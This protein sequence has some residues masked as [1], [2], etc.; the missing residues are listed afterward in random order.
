MGLIKKIEK[1]QTEL[2]TFEGY[3]TIDENVVC[4]CELITSEFQNIYCPFIKFEGGI[5]EIQPLGEEGKY[6][7]RYLC[8]KRYITDFNN[9]LN[10]EE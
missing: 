6:T 7:F 2:D 5:Q 4:Y 9:D 8:L 10:K 1:C 3:G